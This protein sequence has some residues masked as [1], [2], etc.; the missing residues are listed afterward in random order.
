MEIQISE[1]YISTYAAESACDIP[2]IDI[3][4]KYQILPTDIFDEVLKLIY[5]N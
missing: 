1:D 3:K 5:D 2:L 4:N